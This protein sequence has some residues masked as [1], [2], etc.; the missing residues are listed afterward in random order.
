MNRTLVHATFNK[1][2]S[3][4]NCNRQAEI[5]IRYPFLEYASQNVLAYANAA[6]KVFPQDEFLSNIP[7]SNWIDINNLFERFEIEDTALMQV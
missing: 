7:I 2:L 1:L 4:S 5:L 3:E 6:A